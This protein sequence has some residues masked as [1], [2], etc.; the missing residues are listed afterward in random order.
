M[1]SQV[2]M[3]AASEGCAMRPAGW[4]AGGR[5][6]ELEDGGARTQ[7]LKEI[8]AWLTPTVLSCSSSWNL[9]GNAGAMMVSMR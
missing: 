6:L 7:L 2:E 5:E 4:R 3:H 1:H 8:E 9:I